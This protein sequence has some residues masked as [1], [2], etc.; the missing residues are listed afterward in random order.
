MIVYLVQKLHWQY[1]DVFYEIFDHLP[2]QA[3]VDQR[4]AEVYRQKLEAVERERW[5]KRDARTCRGELVM[6][7]EFY[8]VIA[9][10][11]EP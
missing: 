1:N 8:Q 10:E 7:Q 4:D 5:E 6:D 3:F 9:V 11:Y 2:M